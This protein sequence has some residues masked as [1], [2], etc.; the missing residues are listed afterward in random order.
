MNIIVGPFVGGLE[1]ELFTFR[2]YATWLYKGL[3]SHCENFYLS[4]HDKHRFLYNWNDINFVPVNS[5]FGNDEDHQ[6]IMNLKVNNKEYLTMVKQLKNNVKKDEDV[7]HC[8]VRY[9]KYDNFTI[10]LAKKVFDKVKLDVEHNNEVLIISRQGNF[11]IIKQLCKA[12][13]DA[14]EINN[15]C[16]SID[17][18]KIVLGAKLVICS[19]GVW[20][21]FCNLHGVPVFS[22]GTDIGGYK[23]TGVYH[24]NNK[25]SHVIYHDSNNIDTILSGIEYLINKVEK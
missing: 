23:P 21:Y 7:V 12:L 5:E 9:T 13:P 25:K 18:L 17:L 10:P 8:N 22:W 14:I 4:T 11:N 3:R 19:C 1:Q 24:F 20:T 16:S 6:G 2:P 15:H